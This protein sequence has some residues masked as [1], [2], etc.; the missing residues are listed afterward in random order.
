M[1]TYQALVEDLR[2]MVPGVARAAA[3]DKV[4]G[5]A[6]WRA[7]SDLVQEAA[8]HHDVTDPRMPRSSAT[9]TVPADLTTGIDLSSITDLLKIQ[10]VQ[11]E[12]SDSVRAS[13]TIV[14]FKNRFD[15][16]EPTPAACI[17]GNTLYPIPAD[18]DGIWTH[19][20]MAAANWSNVSTLT[21]KYIPTVTEISALSDTVPVNEVFHRPGIYRSGVDIVAAH[22]PELMAQVQMLYA[23]AW[24][25]ALLS[26]VRPIAN[27]IEVVRAVW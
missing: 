14:P 12:Y 6:L 13:V 2:T 8:E 19:A 16:A 21:V 25:A 20:R 10:E 18:G 22:A 24:N 1:A 27:E 7:F 15:K 11:V 9:P 26:L 5:R 23:E 4:L 17:D 3:S